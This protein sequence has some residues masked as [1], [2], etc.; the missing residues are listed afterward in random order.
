MRVALDD[1]DDRVGLRGYVHYNK[2]ALHTQ[3]VTSI[4]DNASNIELQ[5]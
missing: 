3:F 2:Y 5:G 4:I 1:Y